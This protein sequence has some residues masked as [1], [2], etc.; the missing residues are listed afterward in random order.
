MTFW[1]LSSVGVVSGVNWMRLKEA[2]SMCATARAR[3]VFALPGGPSMSTWPC[4]TA[5]INS[6]STV[7]SWP[8]TTFDTS[9]FARSRRSAKSSYFSSII[10]ATS[11][12][13]SP[14]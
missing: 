9:A 10:S 12:V 8:M 3:S 6:S 1:P 4:A 2:P 5:A 14:R 11:R 7:R 13:L